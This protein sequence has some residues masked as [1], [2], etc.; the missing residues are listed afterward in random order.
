MFVP[1]FFASFCSHLR[2]LE[3]I[4]IIFFHHSISITQ[5]S[6]LITHHSSL[7]TLNTIHV[8]HYYSIS[9]TQYFSHFLW[10]PFL[11]QCS[12]YF[13]FYF[14]K[15]PRS[16]EPVKEKKEKKEEKK[17]ETQIT[18]NPRK[19][20]NPKTQLYRQFQ[21]MASFNFVCHSINKPR[22]KHQTSNPVK[23]NEPRKKKKKTTNLEKTHT[24]TGK[25]PI[26]SRLKFEPSFNTKL[27]GFILFL[28]LASDFSYDFV[29]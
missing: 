22:K 16:P 23:D 12:F 17:K 7:F 4:W 25:Q 15:V 20:M 26:D 5:H 27:V 13:Y 18:R 19:K 8:W 29:D 9:I 10:V 21:T 11:S 1:L 14:F 2:G 3:A 24:Q 6:S 28:C